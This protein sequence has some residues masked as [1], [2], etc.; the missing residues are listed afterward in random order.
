MFQFSTKHIEFCNF[1]FT[2]DE[3]DACYN[4]SNRCLGDKFFLRYCSKWLSIE[5]KKTFADWRAKSGKNTISSNINIF[6]LSSTFNPSFA[7][8][9]LAPPI[10][11]IFSLPFNF[12]RSRSNY[13]RIERELKSFPGKPKFHQVFCYDVWALCFSLYRVSPGSKDNTRSIYRN[14]ITITEQSLKRRW[15]DYGFL[16]LYTCISNENSYT[17][18]FLAYFSIPFPSPLSLFISFIPRIII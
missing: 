7:A 11:I 5:F 2:I 17:Y 4:F 6:L 3:T 8:F 13:L 12:T 14:T 18:S 16:L 1:I 9:T 10:W 15:Q